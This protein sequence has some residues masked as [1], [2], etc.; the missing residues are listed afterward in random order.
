MNKRWTRD[1]HSIGSLLRGSKVEAT[2]EFRYFLDGRLRLELS[3]ATAD[4]RPTLRSATSG[5]GF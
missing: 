1:E 3:V 2:P 4:P 5:I